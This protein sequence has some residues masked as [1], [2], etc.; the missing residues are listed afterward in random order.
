MRD[1]HTE[2]IR[3]PDPTRP[4][5]ERYLTRW[6]VSLVVTDGAD[7]GHEVA[8]ETHRVT[9]GRGDSADLQL[10]DPGI[11]SEHAAVEFAG[12]GYRLRDLASRNGTRLNGGAVQVSELKNGDRIQLG[13]RE[14]RFVLVERPPRAVTYEVP[15]D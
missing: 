14:V 8:V 9:L 7:A 15:I 10:A 5:L 4:D 12:S 3:Q 2:Q 1:G 6:Q 13:A 11:S